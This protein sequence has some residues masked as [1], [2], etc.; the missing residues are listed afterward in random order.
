MAL[1]RMSL[2]VN[3]VRRVQLPSRFRND[4]LLFFFLVLFFVFSP[5]LLLTFDLLC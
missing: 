5:F 2:G 3:Y 1:V 4:F